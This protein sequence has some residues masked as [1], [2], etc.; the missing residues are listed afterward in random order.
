M[1]LSVEPLER[2]WAG[3]VRG[4]ARVLDVTTATVYRW[5]REGV[6]VYAADRAAVALG[7]HPGEL[8]PAWWQQSE[9]RVGRPRMPKF[10]RDLRAAALVESWR[11]RLDCDGAA[12]RAARRFFEAA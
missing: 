6:P 12:G 2:R 8:W 5:R 4:L 11:L 9:P 3:S 1:N 7:A 10:V